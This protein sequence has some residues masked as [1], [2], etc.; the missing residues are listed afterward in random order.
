VLAI[1]KVSPAFVGTS[2]IT[3]EDRSPRVVL[4]ANRGHD[5]ARTARLERAVFRNDLTPQAALDAVCDREGEMD[6]VSEVSPTDA[7]RVEQSEHA[8]LVVVDANRL[9]VGLFN[10]RDDHDAPLGDVRMREALNLAVDRHRMAAE[11]MA[12]YA[13]PLAGMTPA[14]CN[15]VFPGAEPRRRDAARAA[16]LMA[17]A[18]WSSGRALR[19]AA[20]A[21]LEGLARMA[22]ADIEDALSVH[23]DVIAVPPEDEFAGARR[24]FEKKL[25]L[26]W[27]VLLHPWFDLSSDMPPAFVH[28]E[29]FGHDGAFRAGPED[30]EFDRRFAALARTTDPDEARRQAEEVDRYCFEQSL[31]LFLVAPQALYAVNR[32]VDFK[33]YRATFELADT[34]VAPEHWSR[35]EA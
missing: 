29:F 13:T 17:A 33:A 27:D 1:Q 30:E 34:E 3:G 21:A 19:L 23:V 18:G 35:R 28:R 7:A 5:T 24:L 15:G 14:W 25:P 2:I 31:A 16:E 20:P 6:I 9:I 26:G 10:R 22:A 4:E 11:G 32:H 8:R 12:G